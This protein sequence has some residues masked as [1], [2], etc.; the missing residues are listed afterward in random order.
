MTIIRDYAHCPDKARN[1]VLALGNFDGVHRGHQAVISRATDIAK[2]YGLPSAVMT[3]EPHPRAVLVPGT[4]PFRISSFRQKAEKILALRIDFLFAAHFTS[5]FSQLSGEAFVRDVL[6]HHLSVSHVV[7]GHDF[8]FGHKRSGNTAL[9]ERLSREMNFSVTQVH[10]VTVEGQAFSSTRIR[11][12]LRQGDIP[13]ACA[14]L[15]HAYELEGRVIRGEQNGKKLGFPTANMRLK[16]Y[17]PPAFG[18]YAAEV[19]SDSWRKAVINIG[20][21]PTFG[22]HQPLLEAHLLDF[23]ENLYGRRI[24]VRIHAFLRAEQKF[25]NIESLKTQI[26]RDCE[27]A[28]QY[29]EKNIQK[30]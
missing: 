6:R 18:V 26:A 21:K 28:R 27:T 4:P 30:A 3:F 20:K 19:Y 10:P 17:L 5:G 29:F 9:L 11:A 7:V 12:L 14:M 25:D 23:N 2:K 24:T 8:I 13:A 22:E 1:A 16:N 15:G